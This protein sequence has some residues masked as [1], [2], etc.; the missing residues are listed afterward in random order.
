MKKRISWL[1]RSKKILSIFLLPRSSG[2]RRDSSRKKKMKM[3]LGAG[4]MNFISCSMIKPEFETK[5]TV[6]T[7]TL[8]AKSTESSVDRMWPGGFSI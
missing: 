1:S 2:R 4:F 3:I 5:I 8:E 6:L 7:S